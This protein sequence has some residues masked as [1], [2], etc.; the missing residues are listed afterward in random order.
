MNYRLVS[1]TLGK[2]LL[3]F[4][5]VILISLFI[6]IYYEFITIAHPQDHSTIAFVKTLCLSLI[7]STLLIFIGKKAK[8]HLMKKE[9]ILLVCLIWIISAFISAAPFYFSKTLENPVDA[10]FEAMSGL[11]TTG[12][13][14]MHAKAYSGGKEKK[15]LIADANIP[16]QTYEFYGTI[17][18]V[19]DQITNQRYEGIEAV[20]KSLLFWR[21]FIQWLGGMGIV[22]LFLAILPSLTGGGKYLYQ[23]EIPGPTKETIVPRIKETASILWKIYLTLT[24]IQICA[25]LWTNKEMPL[26]D[27]FC[28]TFSTLSTGGFSIRNASIGAYNNAAT[29][30]VIIIFMIIGAA[31]FTIFFNLIRKKIYSLYQ[32]DFLFFF[33]IIFLGSA[34]ISLTIVGHD[35]FPLNGPK[36]V[37]DLTTAIR[38]GTFHAISSQTTTGF[39]TTNFDL[40]PS[41]PQVILLLLMYFGGMSCSTAGG[42]KTSRIYILLKI[43]GHKIKN[44]LYPSSI[45]K[46]KVEKQEIDEK[47]ALT[48]LVFFVVVVIFAVGGTLLIIFDGVDPETSISAVSCSLNNIGFALRAAGPLYSFAFLSDFSKTILCFFMLLGRL[49]YFAILILFIPSFWRRI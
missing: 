34:L 48:V 37:Y 20:G 49:E 40:W 39:A 1:K 23:I 7:I 47:T 11:T 41:A 31:N 8:G 18:P 44:I 17:K 4:S 3:F 26:L 14:V 9:S 24:A 6:A 12:S 32:A 25:L 46:I 38:E 22:V 36:E 30:W 29:E 33:L 28:I 16:G 42:I 2:Y 13:T 10:Y 27:A 19:I 35:R 21:S 5:L 43:I 15:I 45:K